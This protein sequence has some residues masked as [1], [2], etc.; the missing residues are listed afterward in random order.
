MGGAG[1][2]ECSI[3]ETTFSVVVMAQKKLAGLMLGETPVC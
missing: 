2:G 3:N 1:S